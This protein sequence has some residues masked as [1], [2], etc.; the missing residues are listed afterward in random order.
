MKKIR[1][2]IL[3]CLACALGRQ[4]VAGQNITAAEAWNTGA[5]FNQGRPVFA[6]RSRPKSKQEDKIFLYVKN[7]LKDSGVPEDFIK[8]AFELQGG[9]V[10]KKILDRFRKPGKIK[11]KGQLPR[12]FVEAGAQFYLANEKL[13]EDLR[14]DYGLDPLILTSLVGIETFYGDFHGEFGVFDALY[15]AAKAIPKRSQWASR[16]LA[17]LLIY[18]YA[19][20]LALK[21]KYGYQAPANEIQGSYAGAFGYGQF[22][23][24]SFNRFAVDRD[25]D[26]L[27]DPYSWPDTLASVSNYLV[28]HGYDKN[29]LDFSKGS[30]NWKALYAYNHS[31]AYVRSIL[32]L[33]EEIRKK[34]GLPDPLVPSQKKKARAKTRTSLEDL[35]SWPWVETKIADEAETDDEE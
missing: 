2:L 33:R 25:A 18:C 16:E 4:P 28:A 29:S 7:Y 31:D 21:W 34:L 32:D 30:K 17:A 14:A 27:K 6:M 3:S 12:K 1:A 5:F 23:P 26:G 9:R 11:K 10:N 35:K 15:T 13:L 22:L 19:N 24:S 8:A 20:D